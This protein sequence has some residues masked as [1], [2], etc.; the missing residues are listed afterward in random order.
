M[1]IAKLRAWWFHKQGLDGTLLGSKPAEV[2]ERAGWARSVGGANP[3]LTLRSRAGT[4]KMEAE[5]AVADTQIHE[6]P[7]ARGCTYVVPDRDFAMA[8]RIARGTGD[9]AELSI[10][11]KWLGATD[12]EIEN[13][14]S[15][16]LD[17]LAGGPLD[18]KDI[19]NAV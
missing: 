15:K 3:Y 13:L 19:K 2:F 12:A 18:P 11:K 9:T 5:K 14:E 8:L 17:A 1:D 4:S 7:S 6:L 16:V 10:A